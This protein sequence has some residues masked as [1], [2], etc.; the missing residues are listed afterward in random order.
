MS[1]IQR[2]CAG[3]H[4]CRL[5]SFFSNCVFPPT[6][7]RL[8]SLPSLDAELVT[9]IN[10]LPPP[11]SRCPGITHVPA[12]QWKGT[13]S[14]RVFFFFLLFCCL[15]EPVSLAGKMSRIFSAGCAEML[16]GRTWRRAH[17]S[18]RRRSSCSDSRLMRHRARA[19]LRSSAAELQVEEQ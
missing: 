13:S 5:S 18:A 8:L 1:L 10:S 7:L 17:A 15:R 9:K 19:P 16:N 2:C 14:L 4:I 12:A 6:A 11:P 3:C